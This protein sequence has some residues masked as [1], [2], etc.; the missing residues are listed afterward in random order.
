MAQDQTAQISGYPAVEALRLE[1]RGQVLVVSMNRPDQRNALNAELRGALR[2]A[3]DRFDQDPELRCAVL[4]GIGPA[5]CAGGDLK[6]MAETNMQVPPE[7]SFVILG[8]KGRLEKPVIAAVNGYALAGGFMLAQNCD[9]AVASEQARFAISEVKRGRGAPWAVPLMAMLPKRVM[10][11][12]LLTGDPIDAHRAYEVG[13]VNKVV[14][15]DEL[16][17]AAV[18]LAQTIADNA[19][20]SVWAAKQAVE[21]ATEIGESDA[22]RASHLLYHRVYTSEDAAEG[23]RA[24]AEK[25]TPRWTGR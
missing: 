21:L 10:M 16:L 7:D 12:L 20:L 24:F 11:E 6:E 22:L 8:S 5:F 13:L 15:A 2:Q 19:P 4:T 9:L 25:R 23:P 3:F 18:A 17:D 14:P 1:R